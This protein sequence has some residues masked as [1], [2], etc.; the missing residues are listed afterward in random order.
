MNA[1]AVPVSSVAKLVVILPHCSLNSIYL[2]EHTK[3]ILRV[4]MKV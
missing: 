1:I 2:Y 3:L 4:D